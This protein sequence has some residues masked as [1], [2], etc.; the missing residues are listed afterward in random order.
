MMI[1]L[2]QEGSIWLEREILRVY[3]GIIYVSFSILK[4]QAI[5]CQLEKAFLSVE[6]ALVLKQEKFEWPLK[7]KERFWWDSMKE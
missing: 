6:C 7:Q 2:C 1:V 4:E 3:S 5:G